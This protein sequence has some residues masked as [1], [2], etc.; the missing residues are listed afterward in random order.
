VAAIDLSTAPCTIGRAAAV[1]G[2]RWTLLI[3]RSAMLGRTRFEQFKSVLGIADNIL[4]SRLNK[5]V[6][7]G[8][9]TREP[10]NDGGR[11]RYHY[12]MTEAGAALRP[13]LEAL[14]VWGHT[15]AD[16][17]APATT[18]LT[19]VHTPCGQPTSD[20]S[21]CD[22]CQV[23]IPNSEAAWLMPWLSADPMPVADAAH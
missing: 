11:I 8:L 6:A 7:A 10:Y 22:T 16:P 9:L 3:M 18:L 4:S 23:A 17:S 5:M 1:V 21:F 15:Y 12:P 13:I 19:V 2:D 20:G 14:A